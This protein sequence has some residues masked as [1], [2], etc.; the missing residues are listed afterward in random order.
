MKSQKPYKKQN[1]IAI[2]LDSLSPVIIQHLQQL[3]KIKKRNQ[4]IIAA[5]TQRHFYLTNPKQYFKQLIEL[6]FGLIRH[7][8]RRVGRSG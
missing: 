4:F 5:I 8:L 1:I 6:N 3:T 2:N 7:I